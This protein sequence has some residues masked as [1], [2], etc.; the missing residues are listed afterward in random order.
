VDVK[1]EINGKKVPI[2]S[3][4]FNSKEN[5]LE[6]MRNWFYE[7]F[8]DP[9][10]S[11]PYNGREGGYAY[12]FGGPYDASEELEAMF[13]QY[14]SSK[15]IEELVDEL[16]HD[17]YEWSAN[18]NN[19]NDW[20]DDDLYDAVTST[21]DPY[22]KFQTNV[23]KI[24]EIS[25]ENNEKKQRTH[26]LGLLY[27]NVITSLETFYVELFINSVALD[28]RFLALFIEKNKTGFKV[29]KTIAALPFKGEGIEKIKEELTRSI[30]EHLISASWHNIEVVLKLYKDTFSINAT[31]NWP[32]AEIESAIIKRNHLIHRGGKDKDGN[33]VEITDFDLNILLEKATLI[34]KYLYESLD[35]AINEVE[36]SE[37]PIHEFE[38]EF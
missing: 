18:S 30:K 19:I 7:N 28:D 11:C 35:I 3:L 8:E 13:G 23:D 24:R 12:I 10:E 38:C 36:S 9:V 1:F 34:A 20:Y 25:E 26:L 32:I 16:Q 33:I 5:Q 27:T 4:R 14:V 22:I 15:Y 2:K 21:N 29:D 37:Q 17:C 31:N 6:V